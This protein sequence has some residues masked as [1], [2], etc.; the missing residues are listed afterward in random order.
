MLAAPG[1]LSDGAVESGPLGVEEWW[2]GGEGFLCVYV[3]M[4]VYT[5]ICM[6]VYT[7]AC[8]DIYIYTHTR[9]YI[10]TYAYTYMYIYV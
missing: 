8:M 5:Y 3:C 2:A 6:Y 10:Y 4:Y 9:M 7:Y 1:V